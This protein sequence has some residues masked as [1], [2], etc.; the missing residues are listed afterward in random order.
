M[1]ELTS[2]VARLTS[3]RAA[4]TCAIRI[5]Y[6]AFSPQPG[7]VLFD[8]VYWT[9]W[10]V[11]ECNTAIIAASVPAII[12]LI[13]RVNEVINGLSVW[14]SSDTG[15][16]RKKT[17]PDKRRDIEKGIY[18]SENAANQVQ[19]ESSVQ[20]HFLPS[21]AEQ[22]SNTNMEAISIPEEVELEDEGV[23][24]MYA[25]A[26][27]AISRHH[28]RRCSNTFLFAIRPTAWGIP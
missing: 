19:H 18:R 7:D 20:P 3:H 8:N 28:P 9:I 24:H 22:A 14:R 13:K 25:A 2:F 5:H 27:L 23:T 11:V 6:V 12:P 4:V 17:S 26:N 1:H 10:T 15:S 21:S 16:H